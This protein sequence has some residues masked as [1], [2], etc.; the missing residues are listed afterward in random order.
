MRYGFTLIELLITLLIIMI[1]SAISLP[2][3]QFLWRQTKAD[4]LHSQ[5]R[6]AIQLARQQAIT[7]SVA[8]G[9]CQSDN[10]V[11]CSGNNNPSFILR[12]D[13]H[14]LN[15]YENIGMA[16]QL[17]W[18][19]ALRQ[20]MLEFLP[21]GACRENGMF[22]YCDEGRQKPAWAMAINHSGRLR[23]ILPNAAGERVDPEGKQLKCSK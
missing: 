17:Y 19:S 3:Y 21:G 22:W 5:L 4:A 18:R 14:V 8:V 10:E 11:N 20:P 9:L 16:G 7:K 15:I 2:S 13:E 6:Q 12:T 23:D 1:I